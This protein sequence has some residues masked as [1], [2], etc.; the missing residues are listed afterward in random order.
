MINS[1]KLVY[2]VLEGK[3]V[4]Q[5]AVGPL[6]V[7]YCAR[8]AGLVI[9]DF[10]LDAKLMAD[11]VIQYYHKYKPDAV[12]ISADTWVTAE[13][14][15]AKV[16]FPGDDEPMGGDTDGVLLTHEDIANVPDPDPSTQ[17]RMPLM[18]D[19]VR[20]V[21]AAI[22]DDVFIV[23]CFD[24]SPFSLACAM[25]GICHLMEQVILDPDFVKALVAKCTDYVIA[26]AQALADSGA[27]M[28]S[29]GDSPSGLL[30]PEYYEQHALPAQ[31]KVFNHLRE[32]TNCK[33]SLH[34]CGD[35]TEVIPFMVKSGAHV[36]EIDGIVDIDHACSMV[37]DDI[38]IW[39]NIDPA[40]TLFSGSVGDVEVETK[41]LLTKVDA[42]GK[43]RFIYSSG[44]TLAPATPPENVHALIKTVNE[45][46]NLRQ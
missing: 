41:A 7:H 11:A 43:K 40:G 12:W 38:A 31:Q 14:M 36:V 21:K 44:C 37:P 18:Q 28:L 33:L 45:W 34:V 5:L 17:G 27:D 35:S 4:P 13:A 32:S 15:G 9:K 20:R 39:G 42:I 1:R 29:T 22:G 46:A 2:D 19:V 24:Q 6:A 3:A 26:Y 30:G 10:T 8:D 23:A 16:W 25:A